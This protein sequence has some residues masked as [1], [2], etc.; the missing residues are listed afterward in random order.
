MDRAKLI[1]ANS[2]IERLPIYFEIY[3]SKPSQNWGDPF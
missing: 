3:I 1:L 2:L